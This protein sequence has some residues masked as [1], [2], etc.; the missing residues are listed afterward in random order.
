MDAEYEVES[1]VGRRARWVNGADVATLQYLVHWTGYPSSED[2]WENC[3]DLTN[4]RWAILDYKKKINHSDPDKQ[5]LD[6][7]EFVR[8]TRMIQF[9]LDKIEAA[10]YILSPTHLNNLRELRA[11]QQKTRV[12]IL[13]LDPDWLDGTRGS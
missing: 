5:Q 8:I 7:I 9:E 1:I 4:C 3:S 6:K 10:D 12:K 13:D 2:T 11:R